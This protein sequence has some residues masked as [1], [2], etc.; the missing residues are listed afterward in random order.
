MGVTEDETTMIR[1]LPHEQTVVVIDDEESMREGCR[2]TLEAV[3]YRTGT[4]ADGIRGLKLVEEMR[5]DVV[6][7]DLRMPDVDGME[8]L[9]RTQEIDQGIVCVVITGYGTVS[10]AVEAMRLGARD[11]LEKPLVPE[12]ITAVVDRAMP[13]TP[14]KHETDS[15]LP[16]RNDR[17]GYLIKLILK[18]ALR[19]KAFGRKLLYEGRQELAGWGLSRGARQAILCRDIAWLTK[20][21]GILLPEE[22]EWL[23]KC[24]W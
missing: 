14:S 15:R 22:R 16:L 23:D 6:L 18:K 21:C 20:R 19:D 11:Y 7:I 5:P 13:V 3:G 1:A 9:K 17:D 2:Q 24:P 10:S 4:A 12:E 8:V